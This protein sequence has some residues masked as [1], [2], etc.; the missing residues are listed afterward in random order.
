MYHLYSWYEGAKHTKTAFPLLLAIKKNGR[1]TAG[2]SGGHWGN[3]RLW[4]ALCFLILEVA[5]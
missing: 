2:A 3:C 4:V 5:G 1:P